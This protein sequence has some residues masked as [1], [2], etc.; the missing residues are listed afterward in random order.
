MERE[1]DL[2]D[3]FHHAIETIVEGY[4]PERIIIFGPYARGDF[5]PGEP[6]DMLILKETN[7]SPEDRLRSIHRLFADGPAINPV[8]LT[9][10]EV[11]MNL[12]AD[13]ELLDEIV[14]EG[15]VVY[16]K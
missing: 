1:I 14:R 7:E 8:V 10:E 2:G 6:I 11:H 12:A 5:H 4:D 16:E 15:V 9:E 3:A 13:S